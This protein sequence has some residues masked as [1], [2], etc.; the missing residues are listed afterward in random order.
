LK[1]E[2]A[3]ELPPGCGLGASAA[4]AVAAARAVLDLV[5]PRAGTTDA[6]PML[7]PARA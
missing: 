2:V 6:P 7:F 5:D 4:I 1:L 3:L